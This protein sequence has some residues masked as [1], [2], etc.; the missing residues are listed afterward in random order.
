[1]NHLPEGYALQSVRTGNVVHVDEATRRRTAPVEGYLRI[2]NEP[3]R[4]KR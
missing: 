4:V 3:L 2:G 1:V